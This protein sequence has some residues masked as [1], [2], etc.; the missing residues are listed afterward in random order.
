MLESELK[1]N[2]VISCS[3]VTVRLN[4]G[5]ESAGACQIVTII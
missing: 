1:K 4:V 2:A 5:K 3:G